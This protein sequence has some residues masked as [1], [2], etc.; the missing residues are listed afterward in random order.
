[1][2]TSFLDNFVIE[3]TKLQLCIGVILNG[4]IDIYFFIPHLFRHKR[5]SGLDRFQYFMTG[6]INW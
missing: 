1:L 2:L 5:I 4:K 6:A 3:L